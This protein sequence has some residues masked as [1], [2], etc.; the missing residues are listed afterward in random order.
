VAEVFDFFGIVLF[1][2]SIPVAICVYVVSYFRT[3]GTARR[4]SGAAT[5]FLLATFVFMAFSGFSITLRDGIHPDWVTPEGGIG[6]LRAFLGIG[7]ATLI[8]GFFS[9]LGRLIQNYSRAER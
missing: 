6:L 8:A 7:F 2:G 5:C 3:E 4:K 9:A 1:F